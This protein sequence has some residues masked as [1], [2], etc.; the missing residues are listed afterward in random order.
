MQSH[1]P[2]RPYGTDEPRTIVVLGCPRGGTSAVSGV[3]HHS[4]INM[5]SNLGH[6]YEDASFQHFLEHRKATSQKKAVSKRIE[7]VKKK[8]LEYGTWGFKEVNVVYYFDAIRSYLRNPIFLA[9]TRDPLEIS[10]SSA[11]HD[12]RDWSLRL[13]E[14]AINHTK[15][16]FQTIDSH[17]DIPA[18]LFSIRELQTQSKQ[19]LERIEQHVGHPINTERCLKFLATGSYQEPAF[20]D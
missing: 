9:V 3:L 4:G 6:Q 11:K 13:L 19:V 1:G 12:G 10:Q 8:N 16:V 7:V 2:L 18:L 14:D 20:L 15:N 5:G 17:A